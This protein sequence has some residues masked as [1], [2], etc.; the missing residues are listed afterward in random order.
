MFVD[1]FYFAVLAIV[2][3]FCCASIGYYALKIYT[4]FQVK[5]INMESL[6]FEIIA[7]GILAVILIASTY[8]GVTYFVG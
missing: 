1:V 7:V 3:I 2:D 6:T 8:L 4:R 5:D